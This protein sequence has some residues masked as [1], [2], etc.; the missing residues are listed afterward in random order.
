MNI[1]QARC[2]SPKFANTM[3]GLICSINALLPH[4]CYTESIGPEMKFNSSSLHRLV[5]SIFIG[6]TPDVGVA[7]HKLWFSPDE[8]NVRAGSRLKLMCIF[9]GRP[10]PSVTWSRIDGELPK[11]RM[12]DLTSPESDFG[13]ALIVDN[14]H[15]DDAGIY[16]CR[17]QHLF[18]QMHV[19]VTAA[20]YWDFEPPSDIDQAE[21]STAE[22]HC[23]ASGSPTPIIQWYMNGKPLHEVA[24][25]ERRLILDGGR[26]LRINNLDHDVDT[27]VYQ[28][29]A[30][31]SLG[32]IFANAFVNV[33][34][35][36]PRF[37]MPDRRI[38]KVVRKTTVEMSCDVDA[39]PE[40]VVRWVD[41]NDQSIAIIPGKIQLFP[42]HTL[43]ITQVN[44]ADEGLYY[45][46]VSNKYGINRAYNK[47]EVFNPTHFVRVPSPK[48]SVVEAHESFNLFCEAVTDPRLNADYTWTHNGVPINDSEHFRTTNTTLHLEDVRGWHSGSID[49]VVVTD[50]DVKVSGIELIVLD[51]PARPI[52]SEVDCNE[53]RAMI[54][55]QR[56]SDH[57]DKITSFL[58]QMH[59]DFEKGKWQTV[60]E[61]ENT[62]TDFYQ[63]DI[64][65]S[66]WVNYTFRVIAKNSHG[67]SDP[68]YKDGAICR[69]KESFP[70]GNPSNV[71]AEGNEPNNLVIRWIP[72]DKYEWNAPDLHYIVRYRLN[73]QGAQWKETHIEDPLANHTVIRDQPTF[74]EYIVQVEAVNRVGKS[75]IEPVSVTGFSGEDVP[76]ESPSSFSVIEFFNCTSVAVGWRHINRDTVRG[77]FR[78]YQIEYWEDEKPFVVE[79][80]LIESDRNEAVLTDLRPITNYTAR[81]HTVNAHYR[82]ESESLISF[83]TPEG[84]KSF[85]LLLLILSR[86]LNTSLF[87]KA[88][89]V[90]S[91]VHDLRVRAV[92]ATTLLIT[93]QP[94]RQPNGNI[95]GYFL[96][97]ENSTSGHV[98]ETYVLNRQL[99]YLHEEVEPD[100]GY[101]VSV[102]AETN[103][104][105]GPKVVRA[106]RTW[107]LRNPDTPIFKV[108][109]TSPW[110]AQVQWIPSNGSEWAMPGSS[111]FV[112]YS[113][114]GSDI[115]TESEMISLPR[116]HILLNNLLEDTQYRIVGVSKEGSR[117]NASKEIV[118]RS[119]SRSTM[120]HLSRDSLHSAAWFIAILCALLVALITAFIICCCQRQRTGKYAVKRKELEKGHHID[121]EEH[122]F[123]SRWL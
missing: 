22:L 62:S 7:V 33:R 104:G 10:L 117:Q 110:T 45:C 66:P 64:T 108:T 85:R 50:V 23:I 56:S 75:I 69:T 5:A 84:S 48:K 54:R 68:G 2:T 63:A 74:K 120:T 111:F 90:P 83:S 81:I 30:S 121:S 53:R 119:L 34:A 24:E 13:K 93:W 73:Q 100:T 109:P 72:M 123:V 118:I 112:N 28:C 67:E 11:K 46:N 43:R 80:V 27:A 58:V 31:N 8:V 32:Y 1:F 52:L 99:H 98:E 102:W 79:K 6:F 95:R 86:H 44:S 114:S 41:A 96:T 3:A 42:N 71:T 113:V 103:G 21:E 87:V 36:A 122:Q 59:T 92:G 15:P 77:H 49:C 107:P 89:S 106:I 94:P 26:I 18:H 116:T 17:S 65:L 29:N 40:A 60:L 76:L 14:V 88:L 57:G 61:E 51:V 78:G 20:P 105:E 25:N 97:F 39:A 115:W 19:Y 91:K 55:W 37:K 16:E 38:W 82:S 101:K 70:Y 12:K 47:L 35:H 9:G 4:R